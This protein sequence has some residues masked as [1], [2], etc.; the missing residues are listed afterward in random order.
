MTEASQDLTD[1]EIIINAMLGLATQTRWS[2]VTM[3][4]IASGADLSLSRVHDLFADKTA[5]LAE[6]SRRIDR[7]IL[8]DDD[9]N[10]ASESPKDRLFDV[11]MRRFDAMEAHKQAIRSIATDSMFDPVALFSGMGSIVE[12]LGWMLEAA[13]I[14]SS[15]IRGAIR[16]RGLVIVMAAVMRIWLKDDTA[17]LSKTM[18]ELDKRLG[19]ADDLRGR[20]A[21]LLDRIPRDLTSTRFKSP[22]PYEPEPYEDEPYEDEQETPS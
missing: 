3:S 17:D 2:T 8:A 5:V 10:L 7:E 21:D 11:L 12:S 9:P 18:A 1:R 20:A 13:G 14:D 19:Q 22:A 15:G 6:F 4:D 16:T